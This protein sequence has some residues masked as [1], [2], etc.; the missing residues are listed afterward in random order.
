[1]KPFKYKIGDAV[2]NKWNWHYVI[3]GRYRNKRG[4]NCYKVK[5]NE[6]E[7]SKAEDNEDP[8]WEKGWTGVQRE[9]EIRGLE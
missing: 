5:N 1:M 8:I 6:D 3:I 9:W 7:L 4:T 2:I